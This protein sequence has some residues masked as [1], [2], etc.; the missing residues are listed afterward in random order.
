M[1]DEPDADIVAVDELARDGRI[2]A[3]VEYLRRSEKPATR[4]RAAELLADFAETPQDVNETL[5]TSALI[6]VVLDDDN[7]A[8]RARAIDSL[9]RYGREAVD[10][11]ISKMAGFDASEAP[12]WV[13]AKRLVEW[14]T[15]DHPEFRLVAATVL[16]RV[17]DEHVVPYLVRS[18]DDLD[19]RVRERAVRAC[20]RIGDPRAV[21]AL[22]DRLADS[23]PPVRRAAADALVTIGTGAALRRL[24]P[25]ARSDDERVRQVAVSEL[26]KVKSRKSL[27]ALADALEDESDDVRRAA[28]LSLIELTASADADETRAYVMRRMRAVDDAELIGQLL[29][30]RSQTTRPSIERTVLWLVGRVVDADADDVGEV[31][32]ALLD[33][34]DDDRFSETAHGSLAALGGRPLEDRLLRFVREAEGSDDA[35]ER[36]EAILDGMETDRVTEAVQESVEYTYVQDPADYT[37]QRRDD[38]N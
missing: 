34:L 10:R 17:G 31:H 33:A 4:K 36:A 12:D 22:A 15:S 9:H 20:G 35:R 38:R 37:R 28:T 26:N 21:G 13:T 11:L 30:I 29:D 18:F 24:L 23:K 27:V 2:K 19:P 16:G 32:E 6:R 5:I 14:L 8:V 7:E 1:G 3:L 25:A